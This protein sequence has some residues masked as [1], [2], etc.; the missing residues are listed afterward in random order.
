MIRSA[1]PILFGANRNLNR[2]G[3][4]PAVQTLPAFT[5]Y[6]WLHSD[7]NAAGF[8]KD[9]IIQ[10]RLLFLEENGLLND[11]YYF[12]RRLIFRNLHLMN[13][14]CP[15]NLARMQ[16]GCAPISKDGQA[17]VVH[18]LD[19]THSGAW[20]VLTEGFHQQHDKSLHT[21]RAPQDSVDRNKFNAERKR[22]WQN[23][24]SQAEDLVSMVKRMRLRD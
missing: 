5:F 10:S 13:L 15:E 12:E 20:V 16:R 8:I 7:F 3:Q 1:A 9:P 23:T 4:R 18:H 19:Q 22:F 2:C 11:I 6:R 24:A 21:S 14:Q 17:M